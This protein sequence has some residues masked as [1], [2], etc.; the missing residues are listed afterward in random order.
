[1]LGV[2]LLMFVL[3]MP[4]WTTTQGVVWLPEQ[5]II[6]PGTDCEII[7]VV[8]PI[9]QTVKKGDHLITGVDPFLKSEIE[10][11]SAPFFYGPGMAQL[12]QEFNHRISGPE[13]QQGIGGQ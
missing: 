2:V 3:P 7:E 5:S 11:F 13:H 1:V 6:R 12:V 10:V 8:T 9:D 4:L